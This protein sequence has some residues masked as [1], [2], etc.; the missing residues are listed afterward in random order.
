MRQKGPF[1]WW[2]RGGAWLVAA[3]LL[4]GCDADAAPGQ[5][6]VRAPVLRPA[7]ALSDSVFAALHARISEDGGYFDTDNLISN[8]SGYLNVQGAL[9]SMVGTGGA[10]VG[11]GPDQSFSYVATLKPD[12]VFITDVRRDNALHHLLLKNVRSVLRQS[13]H[14]YLSDGKPNAP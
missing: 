11:V 1:G 4:A 12:L 3:I 8:E 5:Q 7:D 2:G 6:A 10:Y 14:A 9:R 13:I